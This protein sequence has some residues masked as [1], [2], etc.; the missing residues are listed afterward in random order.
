PPLMAWQALALRAPFL[1]ERLVPR[2][3]HRMVVRL[4]GLRVRVHGAPARGR[5]LLI[6]ANHV[7]WTDIMALGAATDVHFIAKAEVSGWPLF[8]RLA[9]LQRTVFIDRT[10]PR[11][12]GAQ[13]GEIAARL[14]RG[15]PMVL[16]PEGTTSDGNTVLPFKSSLFAA[17]QMAM[18]TE[19]RAAVQ[20]VAIVY[21]R[22]HGMPMSRRERMRAAWIG[23]QTLVPHLAR[24]M[25]EGGIDVE[26]HFGEPVAF[27]PG[28][29]RKRMA[30]EAEACVRAMMLAA[31]RRTG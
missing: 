7:S 2:L 1:D 31:L 9:K 3:W 6:A 21:T 5:P 29:D 27:G 28:T 8:G 15:E 14:A 26:I 20:P 16:F 25:R 24:L 30:R 13:A 19:G 11:R 12:A 10:R 23:D 18:G 17:A 22:L 4:L